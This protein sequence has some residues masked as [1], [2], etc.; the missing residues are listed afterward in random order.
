MLSEAASD[1]SEPASTLH[2]PPRPGRASPATSRRR[3]SWYLQ[4]DFANVTSDGRVLRD[5]YLQFTATK[6]FAVRFGQMVAP[7]SLER[8]TSYS[9]L[10]VIDRSRHRHVDGAVARHRADGLQRRRRGAAG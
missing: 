8:L 6:Q 10:E 7:F 3:S 2:D 1:G 9:K 4:G 5:A